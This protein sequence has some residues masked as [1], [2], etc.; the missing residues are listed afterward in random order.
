MSGHNVT[1]N[2]VTQI[3][4]CAWD[5]E[6]TKIEKSDGHLKRQGVGSYQLA[7]SVQRSAPKCNGL[8]QQPFYLCS[9]SVGWY[10]R[11]GSAVCLFSCLFWLGSLVGSCRSA[12]QLFPGLVAWADERLGYMI[13]HPLT[14]R[15][16]LVLTLAGSKSSMEACPTG[17]ARCRLVSISAVLLW[18]TYPGPES[19][20][21]RPTR[22]LD[23]GRHETSGPFLWHSAAA[24][25]LTS[26][27]SAWDVLK[28]LK[29]TD[30]Y[31]LT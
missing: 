30:L 18:I 3:G 4:H 1:A 27:C 17:Q 11:S 22:G 28:C 31:L 2:T 8:K 6:A 15:P 16:R 24:A 20:L 29:S 9:D 13:C 7:F 12:R 19:V 25:S 23:T 26:L 21:E 14:R 10:C 5:Y